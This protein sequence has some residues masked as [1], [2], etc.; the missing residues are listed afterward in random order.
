[1][2]AYEYY[3]NLLNL[4]IMAGGADFVSDS[5]NTLRNNKG[6]RSR[7]SFLNG[8][9]REVNA[10]RNFTTERT[11]QE[12]V[13]FQKMMKSAKV[14]GMKREVVMYIIS[15]VIVLLEIF[16]INQIIF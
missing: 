11:A 8:A 16:L 9:G 6:I 14:R 12:E 15:S 5:I 1:M 4:N 10:I 7:R 2:I 3:L 13:V